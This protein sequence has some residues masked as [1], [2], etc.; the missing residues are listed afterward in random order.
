MKAETAIITINGYP[1]L[2]VLLVP[3]NEDEARFL[4]RALEER[5]VH[6][7]VSSLPEGAR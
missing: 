5:E 3:E 7:S 2:K 4:D 6:V 1:V